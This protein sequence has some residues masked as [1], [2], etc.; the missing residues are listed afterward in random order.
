MASLSQVPA[1]VHAEWL[2]PLN[3]WGRGLASLA[4]T[5]FIVEMMLGD[6]GPADE[7]LALVGYRLTHNVTRQAFDVSTESEPWQCSCGGLT[8]RHVKGLRALLFPVRYGVRIVL[9]SGET[10]TCRPSPD[11]EEESAD[12]LCKLLATCDDV[13]EAEVV[14]L[15]DDTPDDDGPDPRPAA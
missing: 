12:R 5:P 11:A 8:C 6:R 3:A 9:K 14:R 1:A 7:A 13:I 4:G 2:R 10:K 15:D